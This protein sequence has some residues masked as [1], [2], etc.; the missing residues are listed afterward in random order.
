MRRSIHASCSLDPHAWAM[1][2][3]G[4][5]EGVYVRKSGL[6]FCLFSFLLLSFS[7]PHP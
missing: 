3:L 6:S 7:L 4:R 5:G 1:C 2:S